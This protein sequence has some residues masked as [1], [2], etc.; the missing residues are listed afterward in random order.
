MAWIPTCCANTQVNHKTVRAMGKPRLA[1]KVSIQAPGLGMRRTALGKK[2][3]AKMGNARPSAR[4]ENSIMPCQVGMLNAR[5][6]DAP[7]KGA[8][9]GEAINT[10]KAPLKK[11]SSQ[12][13]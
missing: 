2:P 8:V 10:D 9:Q 1:L 7:M 12:G 11:D 13:F 3:I 4:A 6:M 5:P